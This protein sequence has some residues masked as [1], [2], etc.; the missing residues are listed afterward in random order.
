MSDW[1]HFTLDM[2]QLGKDLEAMGRAAPLIMA[3]SL[4]RAAVSGQVAMVRAITDDTGIAAKNVRREIVI[5]KATRS[6]P[7]ATV[8]IAGKRIPLIAL[9]A[10]G[11]EPSRGRGRG[12]SYKLLGGRN[13]IPSGFIATMASGHRGVFKRP[14]AL[15]RKEVGP[16]QRGAWKGA[17]RLP[18]VELRGP[19]LPHVFE[20]KLSVFQAAAQESFLKNLAHEISFSKLKSATANL[21][22]AEIPISPVGGW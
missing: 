20:K 5:D 22:A 1:H 14:G 10:R 17:G 3:R 15:G 4:N 12:V 19:S 6:E 16:R 18:I 11:P 2:G 9:Q 13:R 7:V 21:P 8:A